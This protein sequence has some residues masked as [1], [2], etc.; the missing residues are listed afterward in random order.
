MELISGVANA[1]LLRIH[2]NFVENNKISVAIE[3]NMLSQYAVPVA[4]LCLYALVVVS[5]E[6]VSSSREIF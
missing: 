3:F 1:Q 4:E 5:T 6:A 2:K